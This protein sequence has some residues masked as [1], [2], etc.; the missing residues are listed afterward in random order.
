MAAADPTVAATFAAMGWN[1][2][3]PPKPAAS[4]SP[5][6]RQ[7]RTRKQKRMLPE[8]PADPNHPYLREVNERVVSSPEPKKKERP[9]KFKKMDPAVL[10][11]IQGMQS[12]GNS[13]A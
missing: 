4:Q 5:P 13:E 12:G 10:K 9:K 6:H 7:E 2:P 1:L 11:R 8:N 3:P